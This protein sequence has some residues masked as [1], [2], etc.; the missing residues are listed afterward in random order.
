MQTMMFFRENRDSF[1]ELTNKWRSNIFSIAMLSVLSII[2]SA[3]DLWI[4]LSLMLW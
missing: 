4:H 1:I 3:L 2:S